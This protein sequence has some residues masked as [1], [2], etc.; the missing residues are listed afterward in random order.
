M[1]GRKEIFQI[2]TRGMPLEDDVDLDKYANIS[3]GFVGADIMAVCREA[4]MFALRKILPKINLDEPIPSEIIQEL[5][6]SN[7][8]FMQ[9]IN[10]IEPSAMREVMVEIPNISWEDVGGLEEI[11]NELKEAVEWPLKYP[12]LFQKA[13]IRPLNGILLFGP[14]GCGKTLLAIK[15]Y[16][17]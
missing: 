7:E 14:P 4:A 1:K 9:A 10:M 17:D 13:G 2:H 11:K 12:E 16:L 8:D 6:I 3:Y 15:F 5:K